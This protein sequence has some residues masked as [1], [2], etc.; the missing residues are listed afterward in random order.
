MNLY[1]SFSSEIGPWRRSCRTPMGGCS[2]KVAPS[3]SELADLKAEVG[4]LRDQVHGLQARLKEMPLRFSV[5]QYN[6]LAGYLA[7]TQSRG[8]CMVSTCRRSDGSRS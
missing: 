5:A 1:L 2:S 6:I 4:L 7:T 3:S 8:S